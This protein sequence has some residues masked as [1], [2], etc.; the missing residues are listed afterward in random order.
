MKKIF[1]A[2]MCFASATMFAACG[3]QANNSQATDEQPAQE[4]SAKAIDTK[5]ILE[6]I[7]ISDD[8]EYTTQG[9]RVPDNIVEDIKAA[10]GIED[11]GRVKGFIFQNAY[12]FA[13]EGDRRD[14]TDGFQFEFVPK[15]EGTFKHNI[16]EAYAKA[17]WDK[18]AKAAD[19]G[20]LKNGTWDDSKVI[21]FEQSIKVVDKEQ[22]RKKSSW[23]YNFQGLKCRVEVIERG[24]TENGFKFLYVNLERIN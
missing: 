5:D 24:Y 1:L 18:C 4:Q 20:E 8:A 9:Y 17:I 14:F 13:G 22:D 21:S 19:N 12:T 7:Y 23:Y 16:F 11:F 15:D 3:N 2:L 6:P 10:Y